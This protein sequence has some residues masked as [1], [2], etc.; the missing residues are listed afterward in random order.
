VRV[1]P[2]AK[3]VGAV[4]AGLIVCGLYIVGADRLCP[5][6]ERKPLSIGDLQV[7]QWPQNENQTSSQTD[8]QRTGQKSGSVLSI[9]ASLQA[10]AEQPP[11]K[12]QSDNQKHQPRKWVTIVC[13]VKVGDIAIAFLTYCLVLVTG[14]LV[15]AT[16]LLA[17]HI[18]VVERA[19]VF[20]GANPPLI[21]EK[22]E[23]QYDASRLAVMINNYGKT[24]AVIGW[25]AIATCD[26]SDLSKPPNPDWSNG[27]W[28]GYVLPSG[29]HNFESSVTCK[30]AP[31]KV[32]YGR[33]WY[34]GVF[35]RCY[36]SGFALWIK[37]GL[38]AVAGH[39]DYWKDRK[40]TSLRP[41][42]V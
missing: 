28:A 33:I 39:D 13:D 36:S 41:E 17:E 40:E 42:G 24:P 9:F 6:E 12:A 19:Y 11:T 37:P 15:R 3:V 5:V 20:G 29:A 25:V 4:F 7:Y 27:Q 32:V 30:T 35:D 21:A 31:G 18:P 8:N 2:Y 26:E 38:P 23:K 14:W 34:R 10:K 22:P 1:P 16:S